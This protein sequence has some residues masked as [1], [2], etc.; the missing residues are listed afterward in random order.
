M[1]RPKPESPAKR[2]G[3]VLLSLFFAL[4]S[5][6]LLAYLGEHFHPGTS[7]AAS[8]VLVEA[9]TMY[10]VSGSIYATAPYCSVTISA[11]SPTSP[12]RRTTPSVLAYTFLV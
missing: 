7:S 9:C 5:V 1:K 3:Y 11:V 2:L 6:S 8:A 4:L 12:N 10:G